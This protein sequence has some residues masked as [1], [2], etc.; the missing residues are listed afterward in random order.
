MN[1]RRVIK[2]LEINK[3]EFQEEYFHSHQVLPASFLLC[4][5][6]KLNRVAAIFLNY[7]YFYN[8]YFFVSRTI[9]NSTN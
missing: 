2:I 9:V 5:R 1:I 7:G 3:S 6:W 8:D 4:Y